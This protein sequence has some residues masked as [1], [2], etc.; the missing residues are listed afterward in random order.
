MRGKGGHFG[1]K[2]HILFWTAVVSDSHGVQGRCEPGSILRSPGRKQHAQLSQ[3][4]Q[5]HPISSLLYLDLSWRPPSL[6]TQA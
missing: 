6:P 1:N 4:N 5:T 2:M 3:L